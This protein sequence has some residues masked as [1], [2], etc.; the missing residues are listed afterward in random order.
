MGELQQEANRWVLSIYIHSIAQITF[1]AA[2][3]VGHIALVEAEARR[4]PAW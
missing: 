1:D 4:M 3:S 2:N